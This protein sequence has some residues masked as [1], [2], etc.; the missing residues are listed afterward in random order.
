M[1]F[2]SANRWGEGIRFESQRKRGH[3]AGRGGKEE[4]FEHF[5]KNGLN[6][7]S[8]GFVGGGK[9]DLAISMEGKEKKLGGISERKKT[10]TSRKPQDR[11]H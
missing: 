10:L 3:S 7:P 6:N 9:G 5:E 1:G 11:P 4:L 2:P 8:G